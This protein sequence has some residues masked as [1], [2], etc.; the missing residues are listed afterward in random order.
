[1]IRVFFFK[2]THVIFIAAWQRTIYNF[3]LVMHSN[4]C[5]YL[6]GQLQF[7][8]LLRQMADNDE[9]HNSTQLGFN[10]NDSRWL[11]NIQT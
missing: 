7:V 6:W 5:E 4:V 9:G 10:K 8:R 2:I 11:K 3:N 1:M